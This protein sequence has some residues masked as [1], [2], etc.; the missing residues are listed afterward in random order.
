MI[1]HSVLLTLKYIFR[2]ELRE[3]LPGIPGLLRALEQSSSG[4]DYLHTLLRY[5]AQVASTDRLG[6][7]DLRRVVIQ[8]LSGGVEPMT[9]IA[10]QWVQEGLEK[11]HQEGRQEGHQEGLNSERQ[12]VLRLAR[13][14]FGAAVMEQSRTELERIVE[15]AALEELGEMLLDCADG[16]AWLAALARRGVEWVERN[17]VGA[18]GTMGRA[19]V[20]GWIN[21]FRRRCNRTMRRIC[22]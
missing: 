8:T 18:V 6:H 10:E 13:R 19:G 17:R 1:L 22:V 9:A 16:E 15:S 7:E 5:L 4:L 21:R 14:R 11:G 2:D 20:C 3:Q 12:L